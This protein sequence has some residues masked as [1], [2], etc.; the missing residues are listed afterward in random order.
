MA[1]VVSIDFKGTR[2]APT[3]TTAV[4]DS[5]FLRA[6]GIP[7]YGFV[8]MVLSEDE[9]DGIHGVDER[10]SIENFNRGLHATYD[11]TTEVCANRTETLRAAR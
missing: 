9:A 4:T 1:K 5:R 2:L 7:T 11:L 3:M 6:R 8:P 10:I